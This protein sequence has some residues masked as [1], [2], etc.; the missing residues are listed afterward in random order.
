MNAPLKTKPRK[1]EFSWQDP[2]LL[3]AQLSEQ[4]RMVRE[5]ARDYAQSKLAPR[6]LEAFRNEKT[7]PEIFREMGGLGFFGSTLPAEYGCAGL[8]YVS[9]GLVA[10]ELERVDSGYRSTMSVQSSLVM[11][12]IFEF[13]S[14]EHRKKF[15]PRLAKGELIGC[16]GLTEPNHGSDPASMQTRAKKVAGGYSLT[17]SKTWISNAPIASPQA[18]GPRG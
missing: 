10:R 5:A 13:G 15:L 16:F 4:E 1:N 9:Y 8:N 3:D 2:L 7:D 11:T 12:P 17:G 6:V 18:S 14:E